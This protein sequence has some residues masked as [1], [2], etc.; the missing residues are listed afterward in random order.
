[1]TLAFPGRDRVPST[2]TA[3]RTRM[4]PL[5]SHAGRRGF[6]WISVAAEWS[7]VRGGSARASGRAEGSTPLPFLN[8]TVERNPDLVRAAVRLH[9]SGR[10]PPNTFVLDLDTIAANAELIKAEA[11]RLDLS[12][13]FM[14]K[15]LG[16]APAVTRAITGDGRART[17]A[18]DI[19]DV[20]ALHENGVPVGHCG[21][22]T[23]IS[24]AEL[25]YVLGRVRPDVMS[26][27]SV[28][29][30]AA[31]SSAAARAGV[32]QN[33]L[34]RV[35]HDH[36]LVPA[37]T[38]GGLLLDELDDAVRA[39]QSLPNVHI[40]GVSTWPALT[41]ASAT[42]PQIAPNFK[43][44]LQ[45]IEYL[46]R[47]GIAVRQVNAPGNTCAGV[48]ASLKD[49][50]ATHVEPGSAL[51]GHTTFHL[52]GELSPEQPALVYLSEVS[53]LV[54]SDVWFF[55]GGLFLD[56]PP[57]PELQDFGSR[58]QAL[59]GDDPDT[60]L[61]GRTRFLG[62]SGSASGTF[63]GIDYYGTADPGDLKVRVG[64][65]VVMGF[66]TQA[67]VTR[68]NVAV[69]RDCGSDNPVLVGLFDVQGRPLDPDTWW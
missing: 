19:Q 66:R 58:R 68:A 60:I 29:K 31:V 6:E 25:D 49:A 52:S 67:F 17:V 30:A 21:N 64:D 42:E 65:T 59:V 51:T 28:E 22:V 44:M 43:T 2:Y 13:Y 57:V 27:F 45:A 10:L 34:L 63:G 16:R 61:E 46:E 35:R 56:D 9:R 18:V 20:K 53:H 69:V 50:G 40:A 54:G 11:E 3:N 36:D 26:V 8:R 5:S 39:I 47:A 7:G 32:E 4:K 48:L 62:R 23:Q 24:N 33:L 12:V 38:A 14:T 41:Y 37:G 1:M 55:G 15:Q